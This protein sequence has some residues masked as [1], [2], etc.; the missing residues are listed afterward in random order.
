MS[1]DTPRVYH[2]TAGRL[3]QGVCIAVEHCFPKELSWT[4]SGDSLVVVLHKFGVVVLHLDSVC[5]EVIVPHGGLWWQRPIPVSEDRVI[6]Q[7][8]GTLSLH[9]RRD[10]AW[11][12][13]LERPVRHSSL[14]AES[15]RNGELIGVQGPSGEELGGVVIIDE[16][17]RVIQ[18]SPAEVNGKPIWFGGEYPALGLPDRSVYAWGTVDGMP[19]CWRLQVSGDEVLTAPAPAVDDEGHWLHCFSSCLRFPKRLAGYLAAPTDVCSP[20]AVD[21]VLAVVDDDGNCVRLPGSF[22]PGLWNVPV[23]LSPSGD[24][25][26]L[27]DSE[28]RIHL[29]PVQ[30]CE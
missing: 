15:F 19:S 9:M 8:L 20:R 3:H 6:L 25:V 26:A 4:P 10:G 17:L 14:W 30:G 18:A 2:E 29:V 27:V 5:L 13:T 21:R 24:T 28:F 7:R 1:S 23:A 22:R 16:D 12:Q 11:V